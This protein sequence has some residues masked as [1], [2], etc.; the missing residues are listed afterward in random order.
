V[1][2]TG[3]S[4]VML[5]ALGIIVV[6]AV[7]TPLANQ[8]TGLATSKSFT[9]YTTNPSFETGDFTAWNEAGNCINS[10]CT[11]TNSGGAPDGSYYVHNV[12]STVSGGGSLFISQTPPTN[13]GCQSA[14]NCI[15]TLNLISSFKTYM[16]SPV[17]TACVVSGGN[18][19]N[20]LFNPEI[21]FNN[22][23]QCVEFY[24]E[25]PTVTNPPSNSSSQLWLNMKYQCPWTQSN[26]FCLFSATNYL[27][28][29]Q[30]YFTGQG[31]PLT[32][33]NEVDVTTSC[34]AVNAGS[35]S[36]GATI[37]YD[38][39]GLGQA[40]ATANLNVTSSPGLVQGSELLPLAV[41]FVG[42]GLVV[43][44]RRQETGI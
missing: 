22:F 21:C 17:T 5:I 37:D 42:L 11:V 23:G 36:G 31:H 19:A 30:T 38:L 43:Y 27:T 18:G 7:I 13:T 41:A 3:F 39:V 2:A 44:T 12:L 34:G 26:T 29:V 33:Y 24:S 9:Y 8:T 4:G 35:C 40:G 10:T 1:V 6:G 16:H 15:K 14:S 28:P 20:C 32:E 25:D